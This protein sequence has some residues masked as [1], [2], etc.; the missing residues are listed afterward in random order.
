M[1]EVDG[2]LWCERRW[3]DSV[4]G[5]TVS[6]FSAHDDDVSSEGRSSAAFDG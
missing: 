2:W 4:M 5:V 6:A 3:S 1:M